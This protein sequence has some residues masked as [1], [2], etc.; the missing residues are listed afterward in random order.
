M[1]GGGMGEVQGFE[2]RKYV[3]IAALAL[4]LIA[5]A[6]CASTSEP[7]NTGEEV[8]GEISDPIEPFNRGVLAFNMTLDRYVLRP[9]TRVY[10]NVF[11]D[12]LRASIHVILELVATPIVAANELLQGELDRF[13][14][15]MARFATNITLGMGVMDIAGEAAPQHDEDFGQTLAVWGVPSGPYLVLPFI[16]PSSIRDGIGFGA[17]AYASPVSR[18][19]NLATDSDVILYSYAGSQI[20]ASILDKRSQLLGQIEELEKTSLDFYATVRSL[21]VQKRRSEIRNGEITEPLPIPE[22]SFENEDEEKPKPG[23][24]GPVDTSASQPQASIVR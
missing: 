22:I 11:P 21:Y 18:L 16:G 3:R 9:L 4:A 1:S 19:V 17:D 10:V 23:S 6:G 24:G 7:E 5:P 15:T 12:F 13:M 14:G 2:W 20:G 8:A